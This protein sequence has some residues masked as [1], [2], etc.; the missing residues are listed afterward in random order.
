M[1][2]TTFGCCGGWMW[3]VGKGTQALREMVWKRL[4]R[5]KPMNV[6][7]ICTLHIGSGLNCLFCV[8]SWTL[9]L[10]IDSCWFELPGVLLLPAGRAAE[11]LEVEYHIILSSVLGGCIIF[12]YSRH[13]VHNMLICCNKRLSVFRRWL[14]RKHCF[15]S[16]YNVV[17]QSCVHAV[18][19]HTI[20]GQAQGFFLGWFVL[21]LRGILKSLQCVQKG[22]M[23]NWNRT[24]WQ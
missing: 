7:S 17:A 9:H 10:E 22:L 15:D 4:N 13:K 6:F 11:C 12:K 14:Q 2:K 21:Y 16:S 1:R 23:E 8:S 20:V 19:Q 24:D 18:L 5:I 3:A